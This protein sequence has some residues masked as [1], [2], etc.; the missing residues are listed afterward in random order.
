MNLSANFT[1]K[2]L[3]FS[4]TA[5]ING[6]DNTPDHDATENLKYLA[7][8][9]LQPIRHWFN[10]PVIIESGYRS[11]KLNKEKKSTE[12]SL[13]RF[14]CA[15]DIASVGDNSLISVIE[16]VYL[17]LPFTEMIA[18][19]LPEGWIHVG[20]VKGRENEK[21]LKIRNKEFT[22]YNHVSLEFL[23]N[24]YKRPEV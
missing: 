9:V 12:S 3:T 18:E 19:F 2:E 1:L 21:I 16:F 20:L 14:G 8:K 4:R 11:E 6:W 23:T 7:Q 17:N 15:A 5:L 24:L 10:V 13:H 22:K